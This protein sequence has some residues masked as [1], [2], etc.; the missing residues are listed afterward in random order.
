LES[1]VKKATDGKAVLKNGETIPTRTLVWAAGITPQPVVAG[2][3][4]RKGPR[5]RTLVNEFFQALDDP[6]VWVVGDSCHLFD[7]RTGRPYPP[8]AQ[9]AMRQGGL[10]A[11]NIL[12]SITG[13][14]MKPFRYRMLGQ[15]AMLGRRSGVAIILGLRIKGFF[16]WWLW[17]TYYLFRLP[18]F[19]KKLRVVIDWTI[20]LF[21]ERDITQLKPFQQRPM[22]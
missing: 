11:K 12:A 3:P 4:F 5:G 17:R 18:R 2:L 6:D 16:A 20:D 19:H 10:A 7:S 21:F 13:G 14:K 9:H 8:T 15:M 1:G 22:S